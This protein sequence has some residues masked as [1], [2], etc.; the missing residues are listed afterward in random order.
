MASCEF[1]KYRYVGGDCG[2]SLVLPSGDLC[3][4]ISECSKD[5]KG[6]L[7]TCGVSDATLC[8]EATLLLAR[9][10]KSNCTQVS[11]V[12]RM[13]QLFYSTYVTKMCLIVG[14]FEE[15][16]QY[17]NLSIYPRHRDAFVLRWRSNRKLCS[18]PSSWAFHRKTNVK[19][20][21]GITLTQSHRLYMACKIVIPVGSSKLVESGNSAGH[22]L[23]IF[24]F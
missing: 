8:S 21:R 12:A 9:A 15:Q 17:F 19:G 7:K 3:V 18:S 14:I 24:P 5:I 23:S 13:K 4:R 6:H 11:P 1:S 22:T 16:E 2:A 10:G 20:E